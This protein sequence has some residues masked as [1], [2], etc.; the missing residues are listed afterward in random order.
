MALEYEVHH[1]ETGS[2]GENDEYWTLVVPE[3]GK[4]RVRHDRFWGN[5]S[6]GE[7]TR[8]APEKT[9]LKEFLAKSSGTVHDELT[10]LLRRL[11][12]DPNA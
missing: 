5:P 1:R 3:S 6:R 9:P 7:V 4:S 10:G 11:R 2:L 12:I 8:S